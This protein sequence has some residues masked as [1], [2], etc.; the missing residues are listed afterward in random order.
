M[1]AP[2]AHRIRMSH[3]R[4]AYGVADGDGEG[5]VHVGNDHGDQVKV[6]GFSVCGYAMKNSMGDRNETGV[7]MAWCLSLEKTMRSREEHERHLRIVLGLLKENKLYAKFSKCKFWLSSVAFLGHM[8]SKDSIMVDPEKTEDVH[9]WGRPTTVS[10]VQSFVGLASYY[11]R[12]VEE[13]S[14]IVSSLTRLTQKAFPFQWSDE[15]EIGERPLAREIQSLANYL[16][17]LDISE[18]GRVLACVE[19][20]S[21]LLEQIIVQQFDDPKLI[22]IR[23]KVLKG[24]DREAR[25]DEEGILRIKGRVCMP[26]TRDLTRLIMDEAHS[27]RYPGAMKMYRD[28]KQHY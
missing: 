1:A 28:L 17:R 18:L 19:A 6:F 22:K 8:V 15:Y 21:S 23:D 5:L 27:S 7:F 13:F 25:L 10:E 12:F 24:K 4:V 14:A 3:M 16:V 26:R 9:D 11:Q 2:V 20:R